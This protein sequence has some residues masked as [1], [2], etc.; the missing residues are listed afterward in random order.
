MNLF[1]ILGIVGVVV[2][3]LVLFVRWNTLRTRSTEE[4]RAF[5]RSGD[6]TYYRYALL[7]LRR[8]GVD[9]RGENRQVIRLLM[10]ESPFRRQAGWMILRDLYPE[11]AAQLPDYN[12]RDNDEVCRE[13]ASRIFPPAEPCAPPNGGPT[14]PIGNSLVG[15][16]P[17][18]VS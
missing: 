13:K 15:G 7:E 12:F 2:V 11:L 10:S 3:A 14:N 8:R 9:I 6:W 1:I 4:L 16:G 17:P 18:S 5:L